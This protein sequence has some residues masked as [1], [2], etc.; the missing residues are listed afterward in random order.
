[1]TGSVSVAMNKTGL[2]ALLFVLGLQLIAGP[3]AC[4]A[5]RDLGADPRRIRGVVRVVG[6]E[7]FTHVV[8]SSPSDAAG[9][10]DRIDFLI[11]GPLAAE[12]RARYQGRTIALE[13][14]DCRER[15]PLFRNCFAPTRIL[16][17]GGGR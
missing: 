9:V 12:L 10:A 15:S 4:A 8:V 6:N 16:E 14:T 3:G 11:E 1:M 7:P 5:G 17:P 2:Q 13:G